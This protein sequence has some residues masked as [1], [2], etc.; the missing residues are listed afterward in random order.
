MRSTRMPP[1]DDGG[2]ARR[3]DMMAPM[4]DRSVTRIDTCDESK[5]PNRST[6]S[7]RWSA[8]VRPAAYSSAASERN[9]TAAEMPSLSRTVSGFTR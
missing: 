6:K 4:R 8:I 7:S 9:A 5:H 3:R 1:T 2:S